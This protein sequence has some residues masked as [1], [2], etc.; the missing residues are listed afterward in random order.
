MAF[1]LKRTSRRY[2]KQEIDSSLLLPQNQEL[3]HINGSHRE[4]RS[5]F[6]HWLCYS[7]SITSALG[8]SG[9]PPALDHESDDPD[10][11]IVGRVHGQ[12]AEVSDSSNK[13]SPMS[14]FF[15]FFFYQDDGYG[16]RAGICPLYSWKTTEHPDGFSRWEPM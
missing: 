13:P 12:D 7:P 10:G 3:N 2:A 4:P 14:L 6:S 8:D 5:Q 11:G 1:V 9:A 16:Q 15:F